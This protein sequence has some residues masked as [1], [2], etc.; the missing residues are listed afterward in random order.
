MLRVSMKKAFLQTKQFVTCDKIKAKRV[1]DLRSN[2]S[3]PIRVQPIKNVP[4]NHHRKH[5]FL[6]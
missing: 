6:G 4:H 3:C 1:K 2:S 5:I